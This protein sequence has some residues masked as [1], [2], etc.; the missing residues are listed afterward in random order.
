MD[1]R[2]FPMELFKNFLVAAYLYDDNRLKLVFSF[3]GK[4]NS[5][6]ISLETGEDPPDAKVFVL[7]PDCSTKKALYFAGSAV[8]FFLLRPR[9]LHCFVCAIFGPVTPRKNM[10]P[11]EQTGKK[12]RLGKLWGQHIHLWFGQVW[13]QRYST[14][15]SYPAGSRW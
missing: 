15:A 4:E 12:Q 2:D 6:E 9:R 3:T 8:L 14:H 10:L 11:P 1:D 5:V 7:T 13:V